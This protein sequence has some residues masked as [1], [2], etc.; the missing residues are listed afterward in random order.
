MSAT[1]SCGCPSSPSGEHRAG[2]WMAAAEEIAYAE[3]EVTPESRVWHALVAAL[4]ALD[5]GGYLRQDVDHDQMIGLLDY[6]TEVGLLRP[7]GGAV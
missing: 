3:L 1:F 5:E 6:L 7:P 4:L 2:C